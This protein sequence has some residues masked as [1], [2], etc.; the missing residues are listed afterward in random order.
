MVEN[1]RAGALSPVEVA[2]AA[3]DAIA[4][5]NPTLN[6]VICLHRE[7]ALS[8][9]RTADAR[10]SDPLRI[11]SARGLILRP[12]HGRSVGCATAQ[13]GAVLLAKTTMRDFGMMSS[14]Y[15][16]KFGPTRNPWGSVAN[17]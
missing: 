16:S 8:Q 14:G 6:A 12:R 15:S 1:F 4:T 17:Q 5:L 13:S 7:N 11:D 9:G 3:L 10:L 2:M